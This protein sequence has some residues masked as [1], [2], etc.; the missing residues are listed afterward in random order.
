MKGK[1]APGSSEGVACSDMVELTVEFC[2]HNESDEGS[3]ISSHS[4]VA[5]M[6]KM[7][8]QPLLEYCEPQGKD[9]TT[10]KWKVK[11][12]SNIHS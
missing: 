12:S 8:H 4:V 2:G 6:K 10:S 7:N 3:C 9:L 1:M 5:L 11:V